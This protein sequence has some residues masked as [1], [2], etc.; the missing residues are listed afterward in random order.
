MT[1]TMTP[2]RAAEEWCQNK[3]G[4]THTK[5]GGQTE[6]TPNPCIE[7]FLE[8]YQRGKAEERERIYK[9][10][11]DSP[12]S[13]PPIIKQIIF[14]GGELPSMK[15]ATASDN[16]VVQVGEKHWRIKDPASIPMS[17][18]TNYIK[19]MESIPPEMDLDV[20]NAAYNHSKIKDGHE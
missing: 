20:I 3:F 18:V 12:H 11:I 13:M 2:E 7:A 1:D 15:E 17:T 14:G 9:A 8:G 16:P 6:F 19:A 4:H 5:F 10:C